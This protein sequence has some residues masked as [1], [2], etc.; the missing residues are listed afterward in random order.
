MGRGGGQLRQVG[1][2]PPVRGNRRG[3]KGCQGAVGVVAGG[4]TGGHIGAGDGAGQVLEQTGPVRG[5]GAG[6]QKLEEGDGAGLALS[7]EE[8]VHEGR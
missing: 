8:G 4:V 6:G 3:L 2:R 1:A 7:Q 5:R